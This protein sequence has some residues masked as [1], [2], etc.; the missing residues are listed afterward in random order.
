M[1]AGVAGVS[2]AECHRHTLG[3]A[4]RCTQAW[5]TYVLESDRQVT[6]VVAV[7]VGSTSAILIVLP[8]QA[9]PC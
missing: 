4:A 7:V 8:T 2:S 3:H 6:S 9:K 5:Y 1:R